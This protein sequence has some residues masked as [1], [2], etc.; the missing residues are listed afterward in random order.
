MVGAPTRHPVRSFRVHPREEVKA[1]C[2]QCSQIGQL[3]RSCTGYGIRNPFH[4]AST[5]AGHLLFDDP[6]TSILHEWDAA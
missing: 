6:G 2:K 4:P 1:K 3:R 5:P